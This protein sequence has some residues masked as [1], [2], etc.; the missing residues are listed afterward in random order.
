MVIPRYVGC[1]RVGRRRRHGRHSRW[2]V[3]QNVRRVLRPQLIDDSTCMRPIDGA[4]NN[5]A[6]SV[7]AARDD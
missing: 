5:N 4:H 3:A 1:M 6:R 7:S 2:P